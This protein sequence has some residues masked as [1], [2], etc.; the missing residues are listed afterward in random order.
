MVE[1]KSHH[2]IYGT[3]NDYLS[4]EELVDTD[5]ERIRQSLSR[6]MV[7]EKH[8]LREELQPRLFIDTFFSRCFVRSVIELTAIL[9]GRP[10][11]ILRYGPGSLV[12]RERA[13][14]AAARVLDPSSSIPLAVVTNGVDA[15][16]LDTSTGK[17]IGY[18]LQ[19][20][21]DRSSLLQMTAEMDI[22]AAPDGIK[23]ERELR[24]LN[25]FDVERCCI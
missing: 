3:L 24:I 21:P 16:L 6:M 18:G 12:S 20:I 17:I 8:F 14:I 13:A 23:R 7:E 1:Q 25:A 9:T 4:G 5:D 10:L 2:Y 22:L 11:M 15:E 19:S